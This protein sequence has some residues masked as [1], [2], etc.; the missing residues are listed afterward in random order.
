MTEIIVDALET[1]GQRGIIN[2]GWG[3]L[4]SLTEPKD[5][6]YLLDNCPHDWLFLHCKAVS[7]E[8]PRMLV[9]SQE[10]GICLSSWERGN[11]GQIPYGTV[12]KIELFNG[13]DP[14]GLISRAESYYEVQNIT[15]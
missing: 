11:L 9:V 1:T 8:G 2:K 4:G 10:D 5:S 7:V 14:M 15:V 13:L 12:K 3:G 6:I